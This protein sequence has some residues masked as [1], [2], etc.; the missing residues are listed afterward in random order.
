M[1]VCGKYLGF[2]ESVAVGRLSVDELHRKLMDLDEEP[3]SV[4]FAL[5]L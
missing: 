4:R 3:E 5:K 2:L 1:S